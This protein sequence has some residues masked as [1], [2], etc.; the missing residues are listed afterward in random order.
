MG[1]SRTKFQNID[2]AQEMFH[3]LKTT[4]F[5]VHI[6]DWYLNKLDAVTK[7][8]KGVNNSQVFSSALA[9]AFTNHLVSLVLASN[10]VAII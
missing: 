4:I 1:A 9:A 8:T 7:D 5:K 10:Y 2:F 3:T 6:T